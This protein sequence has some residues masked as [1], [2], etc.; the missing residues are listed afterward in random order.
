MKTIITIFAILFLASNTF[1]ATQIEVYSSNEKEHFQTYKF[2]APF[3]NTTKAYLDLGEDLSSKK[4]IIKSKNDTHYRVFV[5]VET[6]L[7]IMNEGPHL[8]LIN[9][10]HCT[11]EWLE[12]NRISSSKFSLPQI[13][14]IDINCF[15]KVS[16]AEIRD[17]AYKQGGQ[18]WADLIDLN[19]SIDDY[20]IA[21]GIS[22]IRLKLEKKIE[23][24]WQLITILDFTVPMGC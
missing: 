14:E 24:T 22:S 1:A 16:A 3:K 5:Q 20:P 15:P 13:N 19:A 21:V 2:P 7:T 11:T 17:E 23:G 18:R 9:W 12:I 10:K 6:S 4:I 8:D